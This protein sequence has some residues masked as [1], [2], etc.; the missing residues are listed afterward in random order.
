[1]STGNR[2]VN[3]TNLRLTFD[4][5]STQPTG[6][7]QPTE[8]T[9]SAFVAIAKNFR[10][11]SYPVDPLDNSTL[12]DGSLSTPNS[13]LA[14]N[15]LLITPSS[16]IKLRIYKKMVVDCEGD[17]LDTVYGWC[18][19]LK[20]CLRDILKVVRDFRG[21]KLEFSQP[22]ISN[23]IAN[24]PLHPCNAFKLYSI[25][26]SELGLFTL[27]GRDRPTEK[28]SMICLNHRIA[29]TTHSPSFTI[30][31]SSVRIMGCINPDYLNSI[32][33]QLYALSEKVGA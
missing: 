28:S 27:N 30:T 12:S 5:T 33:R 19:A 9:S 21:A 4:I 23:L 24:G 16:N 13:V 1:M 7:V 8:F 26:L 20:E 32:Y 17:R 14:K 18:N 22:R 6:E 2:C 31:D 15:Y 25:I 10:N 29:G 3:I 11:A